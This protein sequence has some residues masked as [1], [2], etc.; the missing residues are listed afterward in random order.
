MSIHLPATDVGNDL[1]HKSHNA[2]VPYPTMQHFVTH[3]HISVTKQCILGY[4]LCILGLV[5]WVHYPTT[6]V[7]CSFLNSCNNFNLTQLQLHNSILRIYIYIYIYI[8]WTANIN[9]LFSWNLIKNTHLGYEIHC[10]LYK[11]IHPAILWLETVFHTK[12]ENIKLFMY[13]CI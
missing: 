7:T 5:K 2:I 9:A 13:T 11:C 4:F 6:E 10:L 8:Y 12:P 3:V 1:I